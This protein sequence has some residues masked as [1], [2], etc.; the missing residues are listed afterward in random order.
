MHND[1]VRLAGIF[2]GAAKMREANSGLMNGASR[3]L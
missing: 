1:G 2:A 3:G